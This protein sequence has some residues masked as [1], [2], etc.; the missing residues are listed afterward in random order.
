[1]PN[2][3]QNGSISIKKAVAPKESES[4]QFWFEQHSFTYDK[5]KNEQTEE[6]R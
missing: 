2:V 4:E 5:H 6:P 3:F 1:L